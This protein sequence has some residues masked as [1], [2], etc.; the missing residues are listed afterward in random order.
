MA[1]LSDLLKEKQSLPIGNV[2]LKTINDKKYYY[3]QYFVSGNRYT[4]IVD[5]AT[6]KDLIKKIKRRNEIDELIKRIKANEKTV[7]LSN[8][9]LALTG[10]VMCGDIP[11]AS[12]ENGNLI[13]IDET[14]APL[15]I[16]RTHS[17]E[18][19]LKLRVIDISRTN[20]RLLKKALGIDVKEDHQISLYSYALSISD[21]Y[22]FKP[23]HSKYKYND[24]NFKDDSLFDLSL[25]GNSLYFA[26]KPKISPE[27]TTTGSFEKGWKLINHTW[28]L[29]KCGNNKQIF[30]ELFCYRFAKLIGLLTAY[31]EYD[32]GYIKTM[33]FTRVYNFEPLAAFLGDDDNYQPVFDALYKLN[34][35]IARRYLFLTFFDAVIYNVD[36]HN[37]NTGFIRNRKTGKIINLAPNFDNNLALISTIDM[38]NRPEK[39]GLIKLYVQFLKKNKTAREL[40]KEIDFKDITKEDIDNIIKEIPVKVDNIDNLSEIVLL[41]YNYLKG[42]FK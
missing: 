37:E 39:D 8:N 40:F 9:S 34:I 1:T 35:N 20:A 33:N 36:R 16:V 18:A 15:V 29:Y 12:F 7:V 24:V 26:G 14:L 31:Y 38:L 25:K 6:A 3:Y 10:E 27:L 41:R 30:S 17:L 4:K 21:N 2:Y 13:S 22:W 11:V 28:W 19:F 42:L 23:K 5:F 32:N